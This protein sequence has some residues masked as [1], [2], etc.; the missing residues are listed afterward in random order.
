MLMLR[1]F[2]DFNARTPE[3]VCWLL[4]YNRVPLED[5]VQELGLGVGSKIVLFQDEGDF[6]VT[7]TLGYQHVDIL[8]REAW[9]AIP[10]WS[11]IKDADIPGELGKTTKD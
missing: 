11:T 1:V 7:A 10:D 5:Q 3:G 8:D 6:E 2:S 9:V 4:S